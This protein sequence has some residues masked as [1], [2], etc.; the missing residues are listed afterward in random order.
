MPSPLITLHDGL[1]IGEGKYCTCY[2]HPENPEYC[3]KIP[4]SHKKSKKR[5][6]ADRAYYKKLHRQKTDLRYIADH[7]RS[8]TTNLGDG[9]IYEC[10]NDFNESPS[11][12]LAHYLQTETGFTDQILSQIHTLKNYLLEHRILISDLHHHNILVQR[13]TE[14]EIRLVIVDGIG[15]R[16]LISGLNNISSLAKSTIVRR[17]NRFINKTVTKN[18]SV[19]FDKEKLY[20]HQRSCPS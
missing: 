11:R 12:S 5:Q 17:W 19:S 9:D 20:I 10:V 15:D 7:I 14:N 6:L 16:I 4:N 8:C 2:Q 1:V 18:P 3:V 13:R